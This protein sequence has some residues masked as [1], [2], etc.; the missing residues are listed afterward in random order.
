M[1]RVLD[2]ELLTN[3]EAAAK[4]LAL[5]KEAG[6]TMSRYDLVRSLPYRH[7]AVYATINELIELKAISLSRGPRNRAD[8][9]L[10]GVVT[11]A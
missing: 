9:S 4:A 7:E 5:L 6:G 1:E 3:A 10:E 11:D 2:P 8:L